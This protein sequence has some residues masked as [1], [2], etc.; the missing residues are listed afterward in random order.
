MV[1]DASGYASFFLY[2]GLLGTPAI[3]LVIFLIKHPP[4]AVNH[5]ERTDSTIY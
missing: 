3:L 4:Q 1:V 2:A 5:G